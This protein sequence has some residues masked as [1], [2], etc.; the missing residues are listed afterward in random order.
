MLE[1]RIIA[2]PPEGLEAQLSVRLGEKTMPP[3]ALGRVGALA[4]ALGCA[5]HRERPVAAP[6]EALLFAADHGLV[7]EGVSAWP[8]AVTALMVETLAAGHA[9]APVLA[10]AVGARL[11][12]IDVGVASP[13]R[14]PPPGLVGARI[15]SG[16]RNAAR[17]DALTEWEVRGALEAGAAAAEAALARGALVIVPGEM[18]IGN[19]ASAALLAHAVAGIDLDALA[20]PGAGL[21][22]SGVERKRGV[23]ARA[24]A[25]RPGPL[26]PST[27]L[28]AFGGLEIAAMAGAMIAGGAGRAAIVVDGFIAT[29]AALLALTARPVVRSS[30]IFAHRSAEPGHRLMLDHIGA[31]PLLDLGLRLGEGTGGLLAL[32][33]LSAAAA[34]LEEMATFESAG[35]AGP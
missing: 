14:S 7:E 9:A 4:I 19:T 30:L 26:A 16:S 6:A 1:D 31:E 33:L 23:L 22:A 10:R 24:A 11:T 25:R 8:Q 27:A 20:G 35:I 34:V 3:G 28:E 17:E 18:G 15:R 12:V 2:P 13:Y 5:Q 29:C 21:D 32:P